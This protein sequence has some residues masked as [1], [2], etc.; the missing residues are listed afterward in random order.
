MSGKSRLE[1][2]KVTT[3]PHGSWPFGGFPTNEPDSQNLLS[4]LTL[5]ICACLSVWLLYYAGYRI[6]PII[7]SIPI[8][9]NLLPSK[10]RTTFSTPKVLK[11]AHI[12]YSLIQTFLLH[13]TK[14]PNVCFTSFTFYY[15][16]C[17]FCT[18][19]YFELFYV[20][21][22]LECATSISIS[23]CFLLLNC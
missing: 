13:I 8:I 21:S 23:W 12:Y 22:L 10:N 3:S 5:S 18:R 1:V 16:H 7:Q 9:I 11:I 19:N 14:Y 20:P 4:A 15:A 17:V 2:F 6:C